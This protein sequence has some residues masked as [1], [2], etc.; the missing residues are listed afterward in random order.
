MNWSFENNLSLCSVKYN[1]LDL[2]YSN[3]ETTNINFGIKHST[4][5]FVRNSVCLVSPK[6]QGHLGYR[7]NRL[8][9]LFTFQFTHYLLS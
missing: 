7:Q 9:T 1:I 6:N 4:L 2:L 3:V 5:H 8:T